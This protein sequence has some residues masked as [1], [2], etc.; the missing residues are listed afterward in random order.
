MTHRSPNHPLLH[1]NRGQLYY[2]MALTKNEQ[3]TRAH[4]DTEYEL[5]KQA[6]LTNMAKAKTAFERSLLTD[7]VNPDTYMYLTQ[8][9]LLENNID[10][11][12]AWLDRFR[13]GP[14]GVTEKEFLL[15]H[16]N[17]PPANALQA[18]INARRLQNNKKRQ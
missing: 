9:S 12:Q 4:S 17:Y 15:R 11:A 10:Q 7:P 8:I 3:A 13:K 6:A 2:R 14:A 5:F 1:H 18:Q 16:Q